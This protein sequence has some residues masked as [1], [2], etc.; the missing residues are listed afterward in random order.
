MPLLVAVKLC[1]AAGI[2]LQWFASGDG[3][4]YVG[5]PRQATT[6]DQASKPWSG[7]RG[8]LGG[9]PERFEDR[10]AV[11]KRARDDVQAALKPLGLAEDTR[12][13]TVLLGLLFEGRLDRSGLDALVQAVGV[14]LARR[15]HLALQKANN[16]G[17]QTF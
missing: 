16:K 8:E 10:L 5:E 11:L 7:Q 1:D 12:L 13:G 4:K 3:P 6:D 17:P 9:L 15:E 14:E 2:Q